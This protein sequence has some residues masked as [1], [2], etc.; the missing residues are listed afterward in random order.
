M[1]SQSRPAR[2]RKRARTTQD[3]GGLK[4]PSMVRRAPKLVKLPKGPHQFSVPER[5]RDLLAI[6]HVHGEKESRDGPK[7][8]RWARLGE[9]IWVHL[10]RPIAVDEDSSPEEG[11]TFWPGIVEDIQLRVHVSPKT[12]TEDVDMSGAE[13][14]SQL[15]KASADDVPWTIT[16]M[17]IYRLKLLIV[18]QSIRVGDD[19]ILPYQAY[20]P[21]NSLI[22][23]IQCAKV[24]T[25]SDDLHMMAAFTRFE[26]FPP[27]ANGPSISTA[28]R[29][30][31]A[32][33]PFALAIQVAS[34]VTSYWTPTDQWDCKLILPKENGTLLPPS[35]KRSVQNNHTGTRDLA[36]AFNSLGERQI[37]INQTRFQGLWWGP[38]RIWVGDVVRL[39]PGRFQ[40]TPH[41]AEVIARPAAASRAATLRR[42]EASIAMHEVDGDVDMKDADDVETKASG[43]S[44]R[45][46]FLRVDG[47]HVSSEFTAGGKPICMMS[48]ML[49]ELA[50]DDWEEG[51][52]EEG[53]TASDGSK[54]RAEGRRFLS[55][56]E[57]ASAS[58]A[59]SS[60]ASAIRFDRQNM[61]TPTRPPPASAPVTSQ[62]YVPIFTPNPSLLT[63]PPA[64]S[65]N[66]LSFADAKTIETVPDLLTTTSNPISP[67]DELAYPDKGKGKERELETPLLPSSHTTA[68]SSTYKPKTGPMVE[69]PP[70]TDPLPGPSP[71]YAHALP[72]PPLGYKF[73]PILPPTHEIIISLLL[74]SGRY[75][76]RILSNPLMGP[77]V[78]SALKDPYEKEN[79]A[80]WALEGHVQGVY[81]AVDASIWMPSRSNTVK[82]AG[83]KAKEELV[84]YWRGRDEGHSESER[85]EID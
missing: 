4:L 43:A 33:G 36:S 77:F 46:L 19:R 10:D 60:S 34:R 75:Y 32:A 52:G 16:H 6:A 82:T 44:E 51:D 39:K 37:G 57:S 27:V 21:S 30:A 31:D 20:A 28:N 25:R 5:E 29:F 53:D 58:M 71:P 66:G 78:A 24:D 64:N 62:A 81:N 50:D 12:K 76:P 41:G 7:T 59:P 74:L 45:G 15:P 22:S 68:A 85:I 11:I 54:P 49:L 48:G 67:L 84:A 42:R 8:I 3:V 23:A 79:E 2:E 83:E 17:P 69:P 1:G 65:A 55:A 70:T 56:V 80:L 14:S 72:S 40:F 63:S 47:L 61:T 9:L 73:R 26:P 13:S 38:E 35:T 18:A